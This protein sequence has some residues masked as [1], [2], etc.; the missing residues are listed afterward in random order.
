[1]SV[2][3][4]DMEMPT[5]CYGCRWFYFH[6]ETCTSPKYY[7]DA[8]CELVKSGQD[9][10]GKDSRGGWIGESIE[11]IPGWAGYY[12]HKH[13]V[14]MGTRASQCPLCKVSSAQPEIIRCKDCAKCQIDDVYH[15]YWCDGKKVWKEHFCGYAERRTDG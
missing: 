13:C 2:L 11:H 10:Y 5:E 14:E 7:L 4:K 15:D 8:R 3:I 9:W 1:M 6:G 12:T